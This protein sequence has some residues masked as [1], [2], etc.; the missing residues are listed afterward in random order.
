M[1]VA[2]IG[3]GYVGLV[4]GTCLAEMG[5]KV[6]CVDNNQEKI[7]MLNKGEIPIFEYGLKEMVDRNVE[8]ARITF[9]TDIQKAVEES[10]VIF[11]AVGTP[12]DEDGS[13]DLQYILAVAKDIG[14]YINGYKVIVD[15]STVPIGTADLVKKTILSEMKKCKLDYKFDVV[16]NPEFLKEGMAI[17]DFMRP[18]RVIIGTDSDKAKSVMNDLYSSFTFQTNRIIFM[19]IR[20]AEMTKYAANAILA[21]KISFMNEIANL[22]EKVEANVEDVR[23]G[24]GSDSRIGYKFLYPGVGYGGSCF[25]KDIRALIKISKENNSSSSVL[26][27]VE[28]VNERQKFV[29]VDK[30]CSHFGDDLKEKTFAIWGL[31]FKPMTDDM[32]EAPS[33][34]I[35]NELIKKGAKIQ[36][37]DPQAMN[38]ARIIFGDNPS[39]SYSEDQY[40][41][42]KNADALVLITEWH[43]FRHPDFERIK[44]ALKQKVIFDGRNQYDPQKT[45]ANGFTY[46]CVGKP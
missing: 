2:V 38:E 41:A 4:T 35:I 22:C 12:P 43:Q 40:Q 27:S 7:K 6:I 31:S 13:A 14:K 33:S 23:M 18:D 37:Y 8:G 44:N 5:N 29:L 34:I 3:T 17:E 26:E 30:I 24:I 21:T 11:I 32:R 39:I 10:L 15:K 9:T 16:S 28:K 42:L 46:F 19:S 1:K 25:P 36:A 20:S 45:R